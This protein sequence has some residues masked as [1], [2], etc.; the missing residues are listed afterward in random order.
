ME[1]VTN[2]T[3]ISMTNERRVIISLLPPDPLKS[4]LSI[5][6]IL[7]R[8]SPGSRFKRTA[9]N[10]KIRFPRATWFYFHALVKMHFAIEN[11]KVVMLFHHTSKN[12]AMNDDDRICVCAV[13]GAC[14]LL[15]LLRFASLR[16]LM[17]RRAF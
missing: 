2:K 1:C 12:V 6:G 13:G 7:I 15:L 16:R 11:A 3:R 14:W 5:I 17:S 9:T 4:A 8:G 10:N